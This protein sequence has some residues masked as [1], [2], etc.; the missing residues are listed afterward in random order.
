MTR[1]LTAASL[2][3]ALLA[4]PSVLAH[5]TGQGITAADAWVRESIP[6]QD[7][8]AAYFTLT[9]DDHEADALLAVSC[10]CAKTAE[11]HR[12]VTVDEQ[13]RMEKVE[14]IPIPA[15][16]QVKLEPGGYHVMLFGLAKPLS[17]GQRVELVLQFETGKRTVQATVRAPE[18][19][20]HGHHH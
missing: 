18:A 2:G 15:G 12:M 10:S 9:S 13:M 7:V 16:A 6:G 1:L 3:L 20:A 17:A 14:R 19:N 8:S 11:L 5:H 4:G